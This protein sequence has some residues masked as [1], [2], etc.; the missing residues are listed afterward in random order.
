MRVRPAAVAG[1]FYPADPV[2]LA[3]LV[4]AL[5]AAAPAGGRRPTAVIAP[6]AGYRYSGAVAAAAYARLAACRAEA[7][8]VVVLGPAH[9]VRL[10]GMAV[11]RVDAFATPLGPVPVDLEA[12]RTALDLPAVVVSDR[13]HAPE[14][15]IET[16]LPFLLCALGPGITL[17]P[18]L[19]GATPPAAVAERVGGAADRAADRGRPVHRPES[20][21]GPG[22]GAG[23]GVGVLGEQAQRGRLRA[24][25]GHHRQQIERG[26]IV[27]GE[28]VERHRPGRR[29][30]LRLGP[31]RVSW[32]NT[33]WARSPS[34][35]RY[36]STAMPVSASSDPAC[37]I[38]SG[39]SPT[40]SATRS[41]SAA[42]G[43]GA[44]WC[45]WAIDSARVNSR[46]RPWRQSGARPGLREVISTW[47]GPWGNHGTGRP[48]VLGVVEH[49]Q[50]AIPPGQ[51]ALAARLG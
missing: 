39:R 46:P 49:H 9:H 31:T 27:E 45:S 35:R 21:P 17:L 22:P 6:H 11:P 3:T 1:Q 7:R 51:R 40:A 50:P 44:S 18:V 14:H 16:Q 41:A 43:S 32:S 30:R 8:R 29:H 28:P 36:L 10:T 38:A 26:R 19:V 15:A 37:S 5:L 42:V 4:N 48:G 33:S 13:P 23:E 2:A 25:P 24:A 12:R 20:L 47:P 34:S